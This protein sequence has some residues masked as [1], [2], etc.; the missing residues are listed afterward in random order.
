MVIAS[1]DIDPQVVKLNQNQRNLDGYYSIEFSK[2]IMVTVYCDYAQ[3]IVH[4]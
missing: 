2:Q 1:C 3:M 4:F